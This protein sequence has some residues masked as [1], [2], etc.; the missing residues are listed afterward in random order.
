MPCSLLAKTIVPTVRPEHVDVG[1]TPSTEWRRIYEREQGA[2]RIAEYPKILELMPEPHVFLL[3]TVG[4]GAAGVAV[5]IKVGD[6]VA[7]E[8]VRT[9]SEF[10]R[11][12]VA[13]AVMQAAEAW[14]AEEGATRMLLSVVDDNVPA[15]GLYS[16]L[17]YA[18]ITGYR[19]RVKKA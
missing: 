2:G 17:G 14:A 13:R 10:R 12:G 16:G 6:D 4:G 18:R 8:G 1:K 9:L 3:A 5:A 19:Y 7:V 15:V 11:Y